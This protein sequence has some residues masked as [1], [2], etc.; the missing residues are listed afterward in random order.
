MRS[1]SLILHILIVHLHQPPA[2][3]AQSTIFDFL[4][5][6]CKFPALL[7]C[8]QKLNCKA[9]LLLLN[10]NAFVFSPKNRRSCGGGY[11]ERDKSLYGL[12]KL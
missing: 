4:L 12:T 7:Q 9:D 3:N 2:Y 11:H 5:V 6:F 10:N 1:D 8:E